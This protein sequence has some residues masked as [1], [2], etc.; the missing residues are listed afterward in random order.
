VDRFD[1]MQ[2]LNFYGDEDVD[3]VDDG[4]H[5]VASADTVWELFNQ[6]W[7]VRVLHPQRWCD[8]LWEVMSHLEDYFGQGI[9]CNAYL[10][11]PASQGF[12]P[13]W[14]DIDAFIVQ[15]EGQKR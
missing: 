9:G 5:K 11:P 12:A 7:S 8:R 6:G 1:G 4:S 15:L 3:G 10:T 13:H 14:D 2:R